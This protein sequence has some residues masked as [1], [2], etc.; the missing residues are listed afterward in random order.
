MLVR[1]LERRV[2]HVTYRCD[3]RARLGHRGHEMDETAIRL[4]NNP[5]QSQCPG[6]AYRGDRRHRDHD[7]FTAGTG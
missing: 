3:L 1:R 6:L 5:L 2:Q 7:A 4:G